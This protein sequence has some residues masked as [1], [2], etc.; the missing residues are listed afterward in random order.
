MAQANIKRAISIAIALFMSIS[1]ITLGM[2]SKTIQAEETQSSEE[3]FDMTA[4]DIVD[5][6]V[7]G[8]NF[9]NA[10]DA[11]PDFEECGFYNQGLES[12]VYWDSPYATQEFMDTVADTGINAIR[13]PVTWF[14]HMNPETYEV[15]EAWMNRVEKVVNYVLNNDMYCIINVHHDEDWMT[16]TKENFENRKDIFV[17][18]WQQICQ[19]FDGYGEKLLFEGL[20]EVTNGISWDD[21]LQAEADVVN[22]WNQLFVDTVRASGGN[23]AQR[24][25]VCNTYAS[26]AAYGSIS[27]FKMP[28]DSAD[29]RII[30]ETHNYEPWNFV[31]GSEMTWQDKV[32]L[33]DNKLGY[34]KEN[35]I[36]KG[37]PTIIGEFS[38]MKTKNET[39]SWADYYMQKA[40][41]YGIKCFWW[42]TGEPVLFNRFY[43][44]IAQK[45]LLNLL[46]AR[47][48][49]KTPENV[50]EGD[51]N[52]DGTLSIADAVM[53][54]K[55]L[56]GAGKLTAC[57]NVDLCRDDQINVFDLC[58]LKSLLLDSNNLCRNE[59]NWFVQGSSSAVQS[60]F[61]AGGGVAVTI[62]DEGNNVWDTQPT[63]FNMT[64]EQGTEYEIS[65]DYSSTVEVTKNCTIQQNY[66]GYK[67]YYTF[68]VNLKNEEQ[69]FSERFIM[70]YP[71]DKGTKINFELGYNGK[72]TETPYTVTI[73]NLKVIKISDGNI[74]E[75]KNLCADLEN[76]YPYVNEDYA[77]AEMTKTD[78]GVEMNVTK[79][80]AEGWY[81]QSVYGGLT[82]EKGAKYRIEFDYSSTLSGKFTFCVQQNYDPY[83]QYFLKD[84]N[85]TGSKQ[86]FSA[87]FT[88][89]EDDDNVSVI[90][91]GGGMG[92]VSPFT[93]NISNL[94]LVRIS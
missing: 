88:M 80:G 40:H 92:A 86:H 9:G 51:A 59:N 28:K 82:L 32:A 83:E 56:L 23:N 44:G 54:Q 62:N 87:D 61:L 39:F 15:D 25:L 8:Y 50:I 58:V 84:L 48:T 14:N 18:L 69:H 81:V 64:F 4:Q 21:P 76:W 85:Y 29:N 35:F 66:T 3:A 11:H 13:L 74:I 79:S 53:L 1:F 91:N 65:F 49:G 38:M 17:S 26:S 37:I 78:N 75:D 19:R 5:D 45:D 22:D 47:A 2:N 12:E 42:E 57:E 20:N 90:F 27:K 16:A 55:W 36:D 24:I 43:N 70:E 6:I 52:D 10:L 63:Y 68:P 60:E 30:V 77:E 89:T 93:M 7:F 72:R 41:E 33:L 73:K 94:S 71:T 34:I 67:T 46:L 31:T